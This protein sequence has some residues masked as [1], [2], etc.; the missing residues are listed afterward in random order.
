MPRQR[1]NANRVASRQ[2]GNRRSRRGNRDGTANGRSAAAACSARG[3]AMRA[4]SPAGRVCQ[5]ACCPTSARVCP[6]AS[7]VHLLTESVE[8]LLGGGTIERQD[9]QRT[10]PLD[11]RRSGHRGAASAL[12]T[13]FVRPLAVAD[14]ERAAKSIAGAG[15][16]DGVD[17]HGWNVQRTFERGP[18]TRLPSAPSLIATTPAR[19]RRTPAPA[20][21]GASRPNSRVAS[22][23]LGKN[24]STWPQQVE[25]AR[26]RSTDVLVMRVERHQRGFASQVVHQLRSEPRAASAR[27]DTRAPAPARAGLRRVAATAGGASRS[28]AS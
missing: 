25:Q 19:T 16:I 21:S 2:S 28:R 13:G 1:S 18:Y 22:W 5:P 17:C 23:R 9:S 6:C 26:L 20:S 27:C 4:G 7:Q 24:R 14:A 15:R 11:H 8:T 3:G 10:A 12:P